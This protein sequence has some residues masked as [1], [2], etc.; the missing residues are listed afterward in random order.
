M[1][2]SR[3]RNDVQKFHPGLFWNFCLYALC[4]LMQLH[5]S[6]GEA[7]DD[8]PRL[9]NT[10]GNI[11]P[12]CATQNTKIRREKKEKPNVTLES[13][14]SQAASA[15]SFALIGLLF[16]PD[17]SCPLSKRGLGL[18]PTTKRKK[19][20]RSLLIGEYIFKSNIFGDLGAKQQ[21]FLKS[22]TPHQM[23]C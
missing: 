15:P 9:P 21:N 22:E 14:Q 16:Q 23:R 12:C 13:R 20:P 1:T 4:F 10:T 5:A 19:T 2:P 8:V 7:A 11:L 6:K 17:P 18:T 3:A